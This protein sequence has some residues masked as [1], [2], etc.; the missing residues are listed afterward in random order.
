MPDGAVRTRVQLEALKARGREM[1]ECE[2]QKR[3]HQKR[4]AQ[5]RKYPSQ[6]HRD[7]EVLYKKVVSGQ[8]WGGDQDGVVRPGKRTE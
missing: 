1:G 5:T 7:Q 4:C 3:I 8:L 6:K 2:R